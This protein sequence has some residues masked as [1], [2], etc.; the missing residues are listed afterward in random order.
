MITPVQ[1][2]LLQRLSDGA[3]HSGTMLGEHLGIS[4]AAVWK[5]V[6][7]LQESGIE[8]HSEQ[9][10]GYRLSSSVTLLDRAEIQSQLQQEARGGGVEESSG[11]PHSEAA[12]TSLCCG[13]SLVG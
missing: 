5:Q 6:Q 7:T 11:S 2:R 12:S 3:R 9:R 4:R 8:I 1:Q 10:Q 13:A